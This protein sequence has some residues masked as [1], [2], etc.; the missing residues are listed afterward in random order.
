[1]S[2][3]VVLVALIIMLGGFI[4][5]LTGFGLALV[6]VPLLSTILDV[7][8]AIPVAGI[9]GWFVTWPTVWKMRHAIQYKMGLIMFVSSIPASFLGV[10]ALT[11]LESHYILMAMGIVL[12]CSSIYTLRSSTPLFSKAST[13]ASIGV[14]FASGVLGSS[15]G[16]PGPPAIA[17]I[18]MQPLSAD[19]SK[20]TLSFFFM[21]QM[22]GAVVSFWHGG[23]IT[24]EVT[25]LLLTSMPTFLI[26]MICGMICYRLLYKYNINY[27]S[28]VHTMLLFIG[29]MLIYKSVF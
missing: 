15:V 14:G 12:I 19:Q 6:S 18:S 16:E 10:K 7:K 27:H 3:T 26:G 2:I 13:P 8:V 25:S 24:E 23:L 4:Q 29:G 1:M 28:I 20:A 17:Y 22:I 5:G 11:S 21:L 9:F